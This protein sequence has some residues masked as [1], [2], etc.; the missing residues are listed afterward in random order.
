M[1]SIGIQKEKLRDKDSTH[2]MRNAGRTR[3]VSYF[4]SQLL[5]ATANTTNTTMAPSK[6]AQISGSDLS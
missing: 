4:S 1:H 3:R 5:S 2:I 6:I